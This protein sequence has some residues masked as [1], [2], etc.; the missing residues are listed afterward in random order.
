MFSAYAY[1]A[2]DADYSNLQVQLSFCGQHCTRWSNIVELS[3][4][5]CSVSGPAT[6]QQPSV[7]PQPA[8]L[9]C[10]TTAF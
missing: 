5:T 10:G 9:Q 1:A 7:G 6:T 2:P 4:S 8:G 3:T